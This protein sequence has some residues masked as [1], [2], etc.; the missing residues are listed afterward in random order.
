LRNGIVNDD[1]QFGMITNLKCIAT[2]C[3]HR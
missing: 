2:H 3:A 1:T